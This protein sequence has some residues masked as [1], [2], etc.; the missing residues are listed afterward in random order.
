MKKV[1]AIFVAL[2]LV[3][4]GLLMTVPAVAGDMEP[5]GSDNPRVVLTEL[6]YDA[7]EGD[8]PVAHQALQE[9]AGE[10]G[11]DEMVIISWHSG[12]DLAFSEGETRV[13]WS[14]I[15]H[16]PTAVFDGMTANVGGGVTT[17][18]VKHRYMS[19]IEERLNIPSPL[20]MTVEW[21]YDTLSGAGSVWV[22]ITAVE[23][24]DMD[25]LRL[26]TVVFEDD[27]G[28]YDG[29]NGEMFH[30]F[31][32]RDMLETQGADGATLTIAN[33]ETKR[34]SYSFSA[35]Y[36]QD[37][38]QVGVMAFVQ[39]HGK[40]MEV[41]QSAFVGVEVLPNQPPVLS[42]A[43]LDTSNGNTEDDEVVFKVFYADAD[44][45]K[46]N[47]PSEA[48][49][50]YQDASMVI[51][52]A[53]LEPMDQ[54]GSWIDGKWLAYTTT[55]A[56]GTYTYRFT[57][58]DG[59]DPATGDTGWSSTPVTILPRNNLPQLK[60]ASYSPG[61]GDTNM[62][63]RFEIMYKDQDNVKADSAKVVI[64]DMEFTMKT[65]SKGPWD[66]WVYYYYETTLT[67]SSAHKVY[68]LFSDGSDEVRYPSENAVPNWILG[69]SVHAPNDIP[70]LSMPYFEPDEGQRSTDFMFYI[71]YTDAEN[72]PPLM[73]RIYIDNHP[74]LM[75]TES[76]T[77]DTGAM[78]VY[79]TKLDLGPHT[80]YFWFND[81]VNDVRYPKSGDITGPNVINMDPEAI[82]QSPKDGDEYDPG[83]PVM[84]NGEW[85]RDADADLLRFT[86]ISDKE[87]LLSN[88]PHFD[89]VLTPGLHQITLEVNDG[90]GGVDSVHVQITILN[91]A[92]H[93]YF[94]SHS[95]TPVE[96][97]QGQLVRFIVTV[98]NDGEVDA[99]DQLVEFIIDDK[100]LGTPTV[101]VEVGISLD[102]TFE[103]VA[104]AGSH[105]VRFTMGEEKLEFVLKVIS[106]APPTGDPV[107]KDP[108]GDPI[109]KGRT[110]KEII[111]D[112]RAD[113]HDGDEMT[114]LW[115]FG[116]GVTSFE[117]NPSHVYS[118]AGTYTVTVTVTDCH[119][120]NCTETFEMQVTK[121]VKEEPGFNMTL[122]II[123]IAVVVVVVLVAASTRRRS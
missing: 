12:D 44:D 64:N 49:V 1:S 114:F 84:F 8:C 98:D 100:V 45:D 88:D 52:E 19:H 33:G 113:D 9:L 48:K 121:P 106:N 118:R 87:G 105:I 74:S 75:T 60:D 37:K 107:P 120:G 95:V 54:S 34:F 67:V 117:E 111:F 25:D 72:D 17:D 79:R 66:S 7:S 62:V 109:T 53:L 20:K 86:W 65:D 31:V 56:P 16:F 103:W 43:Q 81:G 30:D 70:T 89:K 73:S 85:S 78:F 68:Y 77:F 24:I 36:A 11:R 71:V 76:E 110:G 47:G 35:S 116:D 101:N 10:Y 41:L 94:V 32:A 93:P 55:L 102:L 104:E 83:Q 91:P 112:A 90:L 99:E 22:N 28:P 14:G 123:A 58:S 50:E 119:G 13:A 80:F 82:M 42:S 63:F 26:H 18:D 27:V 57:A 92:S 38:D 46:D 108:S 97:I 15:N 6:F 39:S 40:S 29:G 69:P 61:S 5:F 2:A 59:K 23:D 96:P 3:C 4:S 51:V 21:V 122:A 115:N